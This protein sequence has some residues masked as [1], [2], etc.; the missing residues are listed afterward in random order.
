[1]QTGKRLTLRIFAI[2]IVVLGCA[3]IVEVGLRMA[4]RALPA[5]RKGILRAP[6]MTELD[7]ELG[8]VTSPGR[9]AY[10]TTGDER[11]WIEVTVNAGRTRAVAQSAPGAKEIWFFGCSFTYGWGVT[12]GDD[13]VGRLA[14]KLPRYQLRNFG[15]P[16][17][18]TV[19][20]LLRFRQEIAAAEMPPKLVVYGQTGHHDIRNAA[21]RV[22]RMTIDRAGRGPERL[23]MPSA[24]LDAEGR[25]V[26]F[27]SAR[28]RSWPLSR[29][30]VAVYR[31]E[32]EWARFRDRAMESDKHLVTQ[33]LIRVWNEEATRAG[34]TLAVV[35]LW[36]SDKLTARDREDLWDSVV[37]LD[38]CRDQRRGRKFR[39][40]G[41]AHPNALVH[42]GW[43]DCIFES[44]A[45]LLD[46]RKD[47][48][49]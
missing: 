37:A 11:N 49:A 1:V 39:V 42:A 10:S 46:E 18:G 29:Y 48:G 4:G 15:V 41:D 31:L 2:V 47:S 38:A 3:S 22:W 12:D 30:S 13:Y 34:T 9:Y 7:D 45:P 14:A 19:Q 32:S 24:R 25:L 33:Q 40:P 35:P 44:I 5:A 36:M 43:A 27:P 6:L 21:T 23:L 20:S 16:G 28:Y 17:Y 8:W 26:L